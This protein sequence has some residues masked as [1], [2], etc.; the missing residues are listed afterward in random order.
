[1]ISLH[2]V[3]RSHDRCYVIK[4]N[5]CLMFFGHTKTQTNINT[6]IGQKGISISYEEKTQ[7]RV[8]E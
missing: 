2:R 4:L 3:R 7:Y 5:I 1:M 6:R 8:D